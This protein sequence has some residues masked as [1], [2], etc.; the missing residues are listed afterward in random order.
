MC[1]RNLKQYRQVYSSEFESPPTDLPVDFGVVYPRARLVLNNAK[2]AR[3]S[4]RTLQRHS[5]YR[6]QGRRFAL[7]EMLVV[8]QL[9]LWGKRRSTVFATDCDARSRFSSMSSLVSS[10]T[11]VSE[12]ELPEMWIRSCRESIDVRERTNWP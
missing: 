10:G 8:D 3:R 1:D 4:G 12:R 2:D 7:E 6:V 9:G 5:M 11:V